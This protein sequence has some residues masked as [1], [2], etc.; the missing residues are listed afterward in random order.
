VIESCI[1]S[2]LTHVQFWITIVFSLSLSV[3][4]MHII[5][6]KNQQLSKPQRL[7][8]HKKHRENNLQRAGTILPSILF[9]HGLCVV[10]YPRNCYRCVHHLGRVKFVP[11]PLL[12]LARYRRRVMVGRHW[13]NSTK[14]PP[15]P[16]NRARGPTS[17]ASL[18]RGS[19]HTRWGP[20]PVPPN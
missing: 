16:D 20:P 11:I 5:S 15:P 17:K 4:A 8:I 2:A 3:C 10:G 12:S 9:I 13:D 14:Q 1:R 18:V 19:R 7:V 6:H